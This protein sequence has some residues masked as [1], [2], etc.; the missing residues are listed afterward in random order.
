M[1]KAERDTRV[2]GWM[3]RYGYMFAGQTV[4]WRDRSHEEN[5]EWAID[6]MPGWLDIVGRLIADID[7]MLPDTLKRP[8]GRAFHIVQVKEK[9]GTLR[10]YFHVGNGIGAPSA[11]DIF[12]P[13]GLTTVRADADV[14]DTD[15]LKL[16]ERLRNRIAD[17]EQESGRS[18]LF[19]GAPGELRKAVGWWHTACDQHMNRRG[20][21]DDE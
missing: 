7:A 16:M 5:L 2:R 8:D 21:F 12:S 19:C 18:C 1:K 14:G 15:L 11:V 13:D 9:F 6:A 4:G 3:D 17:A 20:L 10:F